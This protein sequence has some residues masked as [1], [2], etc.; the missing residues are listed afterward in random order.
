MWIE[1]RRQVEDPALHSI[2][3]EFRVNVT[4]LCSCDWTVD[5]V[6]F[7]NITFDNMDDLKYAYDNDINVRN[8][9]QQYVDVLFYLFLITN[10]IRD[11][12]NQ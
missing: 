9:L 1:L 11:T 3:F 12:S 7:R 6:W 2:G 4:T 8:Q 10:I 5:Y